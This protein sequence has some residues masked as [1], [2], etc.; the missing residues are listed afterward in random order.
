MIF[1]G[2]F[3]PTSPVILWTLLTFQSGYQFPADCYWWM[4]RSEE[5]AGTSQASQINAEGK[6]MRK[7]EPVFSFPEPCQSK[8]LRSQLWPESLLPWQLLRPLVPLSSVSFCWYLWNV[9]FEWHKPLMCP[10]S[11][12]TENSLWLMPWCSF[13]G[14]SVARSLILWALIFYLNPIPVSEAFFKIWNL[15]ILYYYSKLN[16]INNFAKVIFAEVILT[17]LI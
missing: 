16:N 8:E 7:P 11:Y 9:G 10:E 2:H 3:N 4:M 15:N 5:Q 14:V 17:N 13:N 12:I 6:C 1:Q